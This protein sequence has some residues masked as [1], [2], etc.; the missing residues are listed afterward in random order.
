[1]PEGKNSP[2]W[3]ELVRDDRQRIQELERVLRDTEKS[4]DYTDIRK[5]IDAL[6]QGTMRL[7]ELMM[8]TAVATALKGKNM[9]DASLGKGPQSSHPIAKADF[10]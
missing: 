4:D 1:M 8:D 9:D 6:N 5:A 3:D 7:A 2:A 10:E